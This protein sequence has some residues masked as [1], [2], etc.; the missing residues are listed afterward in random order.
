MQ[1]INKNIIRIAITVIISLLLLNYL[2]TQYNNRIIEENRLLQQ[3]AED[4][5]VT[6]SQFAIIIIHN[7]DL[8]LRSYAL[9]RD[10]KYLYPLKIAIQDKDSIIRKVEVALQSQAYP[11][12]EFY[13]LRDSINSYAQLNIELLRMF[14]ENRM[15]KFM[16]Y[17]DQDRGYLL[18][19]QYEAF[20]RNVYAYEDDIVETARLHYR[21]AER[22]NLLV[23]V[24]LFVTCVPTLLITAFHTY[25][26]FK[27]EVALRNAEIEKASLLAT[28]N[29]RL[30]K[31]VK[32]RTME[33][34]Q[35]NRLLQEKNEEILAQNEEITA[36]NDELNIH[37]EMLASQNEALEKSKKEQLNIYSQLLR[38]KS[39]M[40]ELLNNEIQSLH[41]KS[42][43]DD[44]QVK[45]FNVVLH[46]T[47]LTD[48]DWEKFRHTFDEV[49]P[50]F[51]AC[52]R[53]RFPDI[54]NSELRLAALIKMNLSVKEAA[55]TLGISPESVK[56][57]RYRL[58]KKIILDENDSLEE[59]IRTL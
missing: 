29:E 28:Q 51:F 31:A 34:Q 38:E 6:V 13:T 15:E 55:A 42:S 17:A 10:E 25:K 21:K 16:F 44:E 47:I 12:D 9:F 23:Q 36:Q 22:N 49:Y 50:D 58:K 4:I 19:L 37:R 35:Q 14:Q 39:E 48:E 7:L 30:E 8:G 5:K 11:L 3:Q 52:L 33:I 41:S 53:Y 32:E 20:A 46:A 40:I 57:S 45:S 56:K 27:Y 59:Y 26:K 18:W 54:T 24:V 2:L 43:G 1:T